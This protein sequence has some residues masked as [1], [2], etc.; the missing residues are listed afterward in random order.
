MEEELG[1][2]D[3]Q[4]QALGELRVYSEGRHDTLHAFQGAVGEQTLRVNLAELAVVAWFDRHEL[5]TPLAPHA[6][7][8]IARLPPVG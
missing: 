2:R 6:D 7:E 3:V 4:W 8:L 1:L 5:P